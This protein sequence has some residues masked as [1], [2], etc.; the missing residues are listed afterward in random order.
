MDKEK[1]KVLKV[2]NTSGDTI[3]LKGENLED[4]EYFTYLGSVVNKEGGTD[5]DICARIGKAMLAFQSLNPLWNS[6]TASVKTKLQIF[7]TNVK[8]VLLYACET[9][10]TTKASTHRLQTFLNRCLRRILRIKWFHK[11]T[12]EELWR[13]AGQDPVDLQ[14]KKRKW[15]WLGHTLRKPATNITRQALK[16][17]PQGK[18]KRGRPRT[19]WRRSTVQ[20]AQ[21]AGYS[22]GQLEAVAQ[23][24][25]KWRSLVSDLCPSLG[26]RV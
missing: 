26:R 22:W 15:G 10:R 20:E 1:T 3:K 16:W 12:N 2:N 14:I 8:S 4:V 17:N 5:K 6:Q 24:R 9:W 11:V 21:Q 19:T 25:M 13:Q 7:N 23:D 18:R